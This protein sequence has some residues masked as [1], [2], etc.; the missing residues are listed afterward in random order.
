MLSIRVFIM[1]ISFEVS[2]IFPT[3]EI[4]KLFQ[5][6]NIYIYNV[7]HNYLLGCISMEEYLFF[8]TL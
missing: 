7:A 5:I 6:K 1:L 4:I 2:C 3:K 8:S